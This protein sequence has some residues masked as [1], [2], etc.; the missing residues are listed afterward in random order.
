MYSL[1]AVAKIIKDSKL[2]N[3]LNLQALQQPANPSQKTLWGEMQ[4]YERKWPKAQDQLK[5]YREAK[6]VEYEA[7]SKAFST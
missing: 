5:R 3:E 1:K 4:S 2:T 7:F 6:K